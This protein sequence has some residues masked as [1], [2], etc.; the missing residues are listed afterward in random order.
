M[1]PNRAANDIKSLDSSQAA[2]E[3]VVKTQRWD[4]LK[5]IASRLCVL[6]CPYD[7]FFATSAHVPISIGLSALKEAGASPPFANHILHNANIGNEGGCFSWLTRLLRED[8][9]S[10]IEHWEMFKFS[11]LRNTDFSNFLFVLESLEKAIK[12][13]KLSS[14]KRRVV[15]T[16]LS[17]DLSFV[18]QW[19]CEYQHATILTLSRSGDIILFLEWIN[20]LRVNVKL[21]SWSA[22]NS[23]K[24]PDPVMLH[25]NSEA[26]A[27]SLTMY[28]DHIE[29]NSFKL[30]LHITANIIKKF[31]SFTHT[32]VSALLKHTNRPD[33]DITQNRP[34]MVGQ[35]FGFIHQHW[36]KDEAKA[37]LTRW[38]Q[39]NQEVYHHGLIAM[40]HYKPKELDKSTFINTCLSKGVYEHTLKNSTLRRDLGVMLAKH[41]IFDPVTLSNFRFSDT[42]PILERLSEL[43]LN[44]SIDAFQMF[45]NHSL[46]NQVAVDSFNDWCQSFICS[47][48][49]NDER[50]YCPSR[51]DDIIRSLNGNEPA[52]MYANGEILAYWLW[53]R[54][55]IEED[56]S[57]LY[58]KAA[59]NNSI[60][61]ELFLSI[62]RH[63]QP[64]SLL[65][66][67]DC[68]T[69]KE[70]LLRSIQSAF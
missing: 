1:L 39:Y 29:Q 54:T 46:P 35:I 27:F 45:F 31:S 20:A 53:I 51:C 56:F 13:A 44:E 9:D 34:D 7:L 14:S 63:I 23:I 19:D 59:Q 66:Y 22:I 3:E 69:M 52:S 11:F 43:N 70:S 16:R 50:V 58:R 15:F 30:P 38:L 41:R 55:L 26:I 10:A 68:D 4:E 8:F 40:L 21:P 36:E 57:V 5:R 48:L 17:D 47:H 49:P 33:K 65:H 25:N 64:L 6:R 12:L 2:I 32:Q 18:N 28:A 61:A 62:A 42:A 24:M 60:H 67:A 37:K